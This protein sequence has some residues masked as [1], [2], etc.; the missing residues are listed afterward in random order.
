MTVPTLVLPGRV[1]DQGRA[2]VDFA[3]ESCSAKADAHTASW[4][5]LNEI[6]RAI[7]NNEHFWRAALRLLCLLPVSWTVLSWEI[8]VMIGG[9]ETERE[10]KRSKHGEARIAFALKQAE[11]ATAVAKV[12]RR[13]GISEQTFCRLDKV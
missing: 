10:M 8:P 9:Q 12:I 5:I 1:L 6:Y 2:I 13:M 4:L 3:F 7:L 11:T